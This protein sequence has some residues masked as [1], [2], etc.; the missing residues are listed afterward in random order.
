MHRHVVP[1]FSWFPLI[2]TFPIDKLIWHML[3]M[4]SWLVIPRDD[5]AKS[6]A[7]FNTRF[8][9]RPRN[10]WA[11][12]YSH[13]S[14]NTISPFS[15]GFSFCHVRA[16]NSRACTLTS[17]QGRFVPYGLLVRKQRNVCRGGEVPQ[18]SR[19]AV[20]SWG[21]LQSTPPPIAREMTIF[22]V[23]VGRNQDFFAGIFNNEKKSFPLGITSCAIFGNKWWG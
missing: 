9:Q 6:R 1:I 22:G 11:G 14:R 5:S 23:E 4:S 3:Q 17:Q 20:Q 8:A 16:N 15:G 10:S 19:Q 21:L 7:H 13:S 2:R 12:K 18:S